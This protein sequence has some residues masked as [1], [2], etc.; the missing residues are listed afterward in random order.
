MSSDQG[1][2]VK[3]ALRTLDVLEL[4]VGQARP[5]PASEIA[6]SLA[7]PVSSL[8]YL[9]ATLTERGY[10]AREGRLYRPGPTL[11]RLQA[12]S[13]APLL[14]D[15]VQPLVSMLQ[16]ETGETSTFFVQI[17]DMIEAI[18][19]EVS[20]HSLQY[21][22]NVGQRAPLYCFAAGKALLATFLPDALDQY[23]TGVEREA[24]TPRTLV[25]ADALRD[26]LARVREEGIARTPE[27]HTPGIIGI[28][29]AAYVDGILVGA[30]SIAIPMARY[31][32]EMDAKAVQLLIRATDRL[33]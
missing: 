26:D 32:A 5:M 11:A 21:R 17:D 16:Q 31:T 14:K 13:A 24:F 25:N 10:L 6:A 27:E 30:F 22:V 12:P 18:A 29:R 2:S 28:G 7:I 23:L 33:H 19:T 8:S 20:Q 3:S 1:G 9:L 4:I 15:R